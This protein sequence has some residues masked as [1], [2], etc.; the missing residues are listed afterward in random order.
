MRLESAWRFAIIRDLHDAHG[1]V[2][3]KRIAVSVPG[4]GIGSRFVGTVVRWG[5]TETEAYRLDV[6]ADNGRARHVYLS[7]GFVEEGMLRNAYKLMDKSRI[8]LILMS[9]LRPDWR[10]RVGQSWISAQLA[11]EA[12]EVHAALW[13]ALHL[14]V[15]QRV[16]LRR[17]QG[18]Q[19]ESA[20]P[21]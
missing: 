20:L 8:D 7:P 19:F 6:L 13:L 2:C 10:L 14:P 12:D 3:L 15:L 4:K 21:Q 16:K 5:F 17:A 9:L 11:C 18:A 1:N